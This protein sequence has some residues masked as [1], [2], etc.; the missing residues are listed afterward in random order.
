MVKKLFR[1]AKE[2]DYGHSLHKQSVTELQAQNLSASPLEHC[3]FSQ[4][5]LYFRDERV[6]TKQLLQQNA[7]ESWRRKEGRGKERNFFFF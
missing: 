7:Q 3:V 2:E 1:K 4:A 6:S 5:L